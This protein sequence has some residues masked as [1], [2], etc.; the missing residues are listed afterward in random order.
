VPFTAPAAGDF[1]HSDF[2]FRL[3]VRKGNINENPRS[4]VHNEFT[5]K[6]SEGLDVLEAKALS[7][8]C[9]SPDLPNTQLLSENLYFN[10]AKGSPQSQY[11][12]LT[13]AN[14]E[15]LTKRRWGLISKR[16]CDN[17]VCDN[18]VSKGKTILEGFVFKIFLYIHRAHREAVPTELWRATAV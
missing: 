8:L 2:W 13:T 12:K 16:D 6:I 17:W 14:F 7:F 3:A 11:V 15:D 9:R 18:W 1:T 10:K 5:S 4:G